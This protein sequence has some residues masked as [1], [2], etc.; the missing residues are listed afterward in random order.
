LIWE[1]NERHQARVCEIW[2]SLSAELLLAM[3]SCSSNLAKTKSKIGIEIEEVFFGESNF[4]VAVVTCTPSSCCFFRECGGGKESKAVQ[5]T[6]PARSIQRQIHQ[7][8]LLLDEEKITEIYFFASKKIEQQI[9]SRKGKT[10]PSRF[11]NCHGR[12]IFSRPTYHRHHH[13]MKKKVPFLAFNL[14]AEHRNCY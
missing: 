9:A 11:H 14:I 12:V 1:T 13:F 6:R 10:F 4:Y 5:L 3:L 7:K 2:Q 8:Q